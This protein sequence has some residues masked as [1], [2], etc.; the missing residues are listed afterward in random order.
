MPRS[1]LDRH[2]YLLS[3][4]VSLRRTLIRGLVAVSGPG[5]LP[6]LSPCLL[7][8]YLLLQELS[9]CGLVGCESKQRLVLKDS[10]KPLKQE[11][12]GFVSIQNIQ[13]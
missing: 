11:A 8:S 9:C 3:S 7:R 12:G 1:L 6:I 13:S 4:S 2:P 10:R 5:C